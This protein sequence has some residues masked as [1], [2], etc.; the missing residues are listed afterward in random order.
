MFTFLLLLPAA[1]CIYIEI[2]PK[3]IDHIIGGAIPALIKFFSPN[4]D[5]CMHIAGGFSEASTRFSDVIFGGL[6]CSR[7]RSLCD[8]YDIQSEP[9]VRFFPAHNLSAPIDIP[10][11]SY[12]EDT[13]IEFIENHTKEVAVPTFQHRLRYLEPDSWPRLLRRNTCGAVLFCTRNSAGC[14][15]DRPQFGYLDYVFEG[16][17]NITIGVINCDTAAG[18][19]LQAG[20]DFEAEVDEDDDQMEWESRAKIWNRGTWLNYTKSLT[21][22]TMI[23][24]INKICG[25]DRAHNGL[26]SERAGR[27]PAADQLALKFVNSED[28]E[29]LIEAA[30]KIKGTEFY[31]KV[32][33]RLAAGGIEKLRSDLQTMKKIMNERKGS[34]ASLDAMKKRFNVINQFLPRG[35]PPPQPQ[36]DDL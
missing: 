32:M 7:Y 17:P 24:N 35:T 28:Q 25:T 4:C 21:T 33:E 29:E 12:I 13:Y 16:D 34:V 5:S 11:R 36:T 8:R 22:M 27:I 3:T 14:A 2:T 15:H 30:K 10:D 9:T 26:L 19:C 23:P 1:R 18:L 31:V 20:I 6:D